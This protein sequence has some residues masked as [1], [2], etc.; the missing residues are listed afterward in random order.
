MYAL[1]QSGY[2]NKLTGRWQGTIRCL[3]ADGKPWTGIGVIW[4][5]PYPSKGDLIL[6][7]EFRDQRHTHFNNLSIKGFVKPNKD[8]VPPEV[9]DYFFKVPIDRELIA[10]RFSRIV[11]KDQF[12]DANIGKFVCNVL[13][14]IP[15]ERLT[16][17][18]AGVRKHHAYVGGLVVHTAEVVEIAK[19][20]AMAFPY[21]RL[22]NVDLVIAGAILHD[23]G[24]TV[25]YFIDEQNQPDKFPTES[26][27][28]HPYFSMDLVNKTSGPISQDHRYELL[29]MLAAHHGRLE[30]GAIREPKTLEAIILHQADYLSAK[31]G[32]IESMLNNGERYPH[33]FVPTTIK[34]LEYPHELVK[35][36]E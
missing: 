7:E 10:S 35:S 30:F 1:V 18:P 11:D 27:I 29:H 3:E 23:M 13:E 34:M 15:I 19:A 4:K 20:S 26:A 16:T 21:P 25:T 8:A 14:S 31:G 22:V 17:C 32:E 28:G 24:K 9:W 6:I 36:E 2:A 12:K 5:E 33:E